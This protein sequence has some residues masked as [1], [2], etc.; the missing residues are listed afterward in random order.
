MRKLLLAFLLPLA[1]QA[2][3]TITVHYVEVP[4]S[5]VG[6]DGAPVRGLTKESFELYDG[7]QRVDIASF[8]AIDFASPE[9]LRENAAAPAAHRSFLLL[10]DLAFSS[11]SSLTRAQ[12]AARAFV[13][14]N[15]LPNDLVGVATLDVQR[16]YRLLANFTTDRTAVAAAIDKPDSFRGP[17]PLQLAGTSNF[18]KADADAQL[19]V[20]SEVMQTPRGGEQIEAWQDQARLAQTADDEFLRRRVQRQLELLGQLAASMRNLRGRTQVVFLSEGFNSRIVSGRSARDINEE[21][22]EANQIT[23]GFPWKVDSDRRYGNSGAQNMLETMAQIFRRAGVVLHAVDLRGLRLDVDHGHG[24]PDD[25]DDAL[26][27]VA[28]PTGGDV[29]RNSNDLAGSFA[30]MLRAQEVVYVLGFQASVKNPGALHDLS[31]KLAGG[32]PRGATLSYRR[33]YVEGGATASAL[34]RTLN[35]ADIITRDLPQSD[36]RIAA[37]AAAFPGSGEKAQVPVVID[38]DGSDLLKSAKDGKAGAEI[39]VYAFDEQGTVRDRIYQRLTLDAAKVGDKL[40]GNGVKYIASLELPPGKFAVKTLVRTSAEQ[41]GY[42]RNDVVVPKS[43]ET[44]LLPPFVLDDPRAWLIV[45]GAEHQGQ[46]YPFVVNGEPFVPSASG[47]A[48]AGSVRKVA[49][50]IWNAQPE[51]L[52]WETTPPATLLAQVRGAGATKLVLQQLN[53]ER[54]A[55]RVRKG[56]MPGAMT[57]STP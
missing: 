57:A 18:S 25:N 32:A 24:V 53:E 11:P 21:N 41:N 48:P 1:A 16:G 26:F 39:F 12:K 27:L 55:I 43:G 33:A 31:V 13:Q 45:R 14:S 5:V 2:S 9:S 49:V 4:V 40:R 19:Q 6:R 54:F 23:A 44:A 52:T 29:F 8:E 7:K 10:F 20:R 42:A 22:D 34:E 37:L 17:D 46:S 36:V 15:V 3:E 47:R 28:R 56:G 38:I 50:F 30:R 35:A 51:E